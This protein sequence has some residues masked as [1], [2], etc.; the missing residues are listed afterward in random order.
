MNNEETAE[1]LEAI[2]LR[3]KAIKESPE[4]VHEIDDAMSGIRSIE[5]AFYWSI[6]TLWQDRPWLVSIG[7]TA[8]VTL[9][10]AKAWSIAQYLFS[11]P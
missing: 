1:L 3:R 8:I 11:A 2:E 7:G 10:I 6:V 9:I 4:S 5:G